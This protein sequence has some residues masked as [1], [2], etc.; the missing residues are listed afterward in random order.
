MGPVT[1]EKAMR[2]GAEKKPRK[3]KSKAKSIPKLDNHLSDDLTI[4][5][6]IVS[7][8]LHEEGKRSQTNARSDIMELL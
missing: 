4:S 8:I 2:R 1:T 5:Q 3:R 6:A 7:E